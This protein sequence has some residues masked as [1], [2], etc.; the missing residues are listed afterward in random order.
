MLTSAM[1]PADLS[2]MK[3]ETDGARP[4]EAQRSGQEPQAHG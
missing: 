1:M 4:Q 3:P 2:F